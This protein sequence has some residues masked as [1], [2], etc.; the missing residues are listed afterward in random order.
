MLDHFNDRYLDLTLGSHN[1]IQVNKPIMAHGTTLVNA[2]ALIVIVCC[3]VNTSE[4]TAG[5]EVPLV[6]ASVCMNAQ[7]DKAVNLQT[8]QKYML[9]AATAGA[10]LVVFPE[11]ALQQNPGWGKV[12]H[13]PTDEEL[14]YVRETAEPIP[15][16]STQLLIEKAQELGI[17]VVFGMTELG[18]DEGLYNTSVFLGPEGVLA[19]YRKHKLWDTTYGGNEHCSW[20]A[21]S[22]PGM[23]IDSP[24]GKVGLMICIEMMYEFGPPLAKAG[25]ELLV[26][27]SAWPESGGG[28]YDDFTVSNAEKASCW[29]I[30]ANQVGN[31]GHAVD[32]GHSRI[33]DPTGAI[34]ADTGSEEG[35]V[36]CETGILINPS[37]FSTPIT[38]LETASWGK[39]KQLIE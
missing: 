9:E 20:D 23:V 37:T 32:Y 2:I 35:M 22:V 1:F 5:E 26:T 28:L 18:I 39:S 31:V 36:V 10:H 29:H 17:F 12:S 15:G 13:K 24:I 27:V 33:I 38:A 3:A 30:V 19:A 7:T 6:V 4:A 21:G 8:F 16:E 14:A 25:A 11:I 34:V